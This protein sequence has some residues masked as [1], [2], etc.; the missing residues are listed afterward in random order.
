VA[1]SASRIPSSRVRCATSYDISAYRPTQPIATTSAARI[2]ANPAHQPLERDG[3]VDQLRDGPDAI[4]RQVTGNAVG[5]CRT[6]GTAS[7][8]GYGEGGRSRQAS[9]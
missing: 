9:R 3:L 5:W 8:G 6:V 4:D 2:S 1:P 7:S